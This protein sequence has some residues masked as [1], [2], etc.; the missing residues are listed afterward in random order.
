[1]ATASIADIK[2]DLKGVDANYGQLRKQMV[3]RER[4]AKAAIIR[5]NQLRKKQETWLKERK[6]V[7][8]K[9]K[10]ALR[11]QKE[12][13]SVMNK[14]TQA[15]FPCQNSNINVIESD[16]E[17]DIQT[18]EEPGPDFFTIVEDMPV[19]PGGDAALLQYVSDNLVYPQEA[20]TNGFVG[21]IYV[22]YVVNESGGVTN[23]RAIRGGNPALNAEAVRVIESLPNHIPGMQ[24]GKPVSVQFTL[25]IRFG[26]E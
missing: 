9:Y 1:M 10:R 11:K 16:A 8:A 3:W 24:R 5:A 14:L 21:T 25:P 19:F 13:E 15:A 18:E 12:V 23:V 20:L 17:V 2:H 4:Q 7:I 26:L 6:D 22:S